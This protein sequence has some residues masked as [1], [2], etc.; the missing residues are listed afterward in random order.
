MLLPMGCAENVL[1]KRYINIDC[2]C[3]QQKII[4]ETIKLDYNGF[5]RPHIAKLTG[6]ESNAEVRQ[7]GRINMGRKLG[8][9]RMKGAYY[10]MKRNR[11]VAL[12]L[13]LAMMFS[14]LS[15]PASA[16]T[17]SVKTFN[18]TGECD[19]GPDSGMIQATFGKNEAAIYEF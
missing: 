15:I 9:Q 7:H 8:R 17:T 4:D 16:K 10:T 14:L 1:R 2:F 11:I 18:V 3:Q 12:F 13:A 19:F 6:G 5:I